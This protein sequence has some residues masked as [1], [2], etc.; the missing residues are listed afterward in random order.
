VIGRPIV[1]GYSI[2][3]MSDID[4]SAY[5][6]RISYMGPQQP[7]LAL[8]RALHATHHAAIPYENIDVL[9]RQPVS[10]DAEALQAKMIFRQRGGYCFEQNTLFYRVLAA[11]GF[12]VRAVAARVFWRSLNGA[13]PPRN[14]M[15]LLVTLDDGDYLADVGYGPMM[16]WAPLRV[17]SM[18]EQET[19]IGVYRLMP[20]GSEIQ[21]QILRKGKWA[22]RYQVSMY[23]QTPADW[24]MAHYY[25]STHSGSPFTNN[26][27]VARSKGDARYC[28][29][30]NR[31]QIHHDNGTSE[32]RVLR[33]VG[34]LEC[35]L[36]NDFDI[37]LPENCI[38]EI[39]R[40]ALKK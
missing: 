38:G 13:A 36:R 22:G 5:F 4:L 16:M 30:N 24:D 37:A 9:L 6:A 2:R 18:V 20:V 17:E 7:S 31:L 21:V 12:S 8:L 15:V 35:V 14:H 26:L 28:L 19:P 40:V 3:M 29:L 32:Q 1:E 25:M 33:S 11:M 27:M 39:A 34:E 10:L 23:E